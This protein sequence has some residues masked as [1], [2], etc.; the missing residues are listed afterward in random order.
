SCLACATAMVLIAAFAPGAEAQPSQSA[1][2]VST[3]SR[4]NAVVQPLSQA[5]RPYRGLFGAGSAPQPGGYLLDLTTSVYQEYGNIEEPAIPSESVVLANGWFLGVRGRLAV[6][7][8]GRNTRFRMGGEGAFRYYRDSGQST[9]PR[10]RADVVL[11]NISGRTKQNLLHFNGSVAYEP[12]YILSIFPSPALETGDTAILPT[13][14][15]DLLFRRTRYLYDQSF[16]LEH[17]VSRRGYLN[18]FEDGRLTHANTPGLDVGSIRAGARYGYRMSRYASLRFGY[19]YRTGYYGVEGVERLEAHDVDLS[20]D[21]RKPLTPSRK[22]SFGFSVGSSRVTAQPSPEW[23]VIATAN[24]RHELGAGWFIQS[25]FAR[26]T[27][28]VEGFAEPFFANT[29]TASVGGFMGRRVE[30]LTSGGYSQGVFGSGSDTYTSLRGAAR[31]SLALARYLAVN[32]EGL[33]DRN[34]FDNRL[35]LPGIEPAGLLNST[36]W[37]VRCNVTVWLPLSH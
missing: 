24:L 1:G 9:S 11:D 10:V 12:Y 15:D 22:T 16:T 35:A 27:Q 25:D 8:A 33:I 4:T 28:L 31:I 37:A 30:M 29:V 17:Q 2:G 21:Y 7:K 5:A 18:V 14:R 6:E 26:D 20:F 23:K 34:T 19:A 32:A 36:R 3:Q 13:N